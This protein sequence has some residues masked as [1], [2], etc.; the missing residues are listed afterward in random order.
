MNKQGI[1]NELESSTSGRESTSVKLITD[2]KTGESKLVVEK[3]FR[4]YYPVT[5]YDKVMQ[6]Y[7]SL[8]GGVGG[9]SLEE[10]GK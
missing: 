9:H 1:T 10:L 5:D 6:L 8:K 2:L 7:R 3:S 4:E